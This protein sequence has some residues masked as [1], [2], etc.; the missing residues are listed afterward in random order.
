MRAALNGTTGS[1]QNGTLNG[2]TATTSGIQ[3]RLRRD[4][5]ANWESANPVLD[6]GEL[7]LTTDTGDLKAGDGSTAHS[8]LGLVLGSAYG[9]AGMA[10][11]GNRVVFL[12][13]SITIR[14]DTGTTNQNWG[15]GWTTYASLL[16]GGKISKVRN[17]GVAGNT[18]AQMLARFDTDVTP[19]APNV[20]SILAGTNDTGSGV[21]LATTAT[22]IRSMVAKCFAIGALPV[23]GTIP[24]CATGT[25]ANRQRDIVRL[26]EWITRYAQTSGLPLIDFYSTLVD[27]TTGGY[28][29]AYNSGDGIH[30]SAAGD[31]VMGQ[32]ASDV[33]SPLIRAWTPPLVGFNTE[34]ESGPINGMFLVDTNSDGVPNNW[35]GAGGS[36]GFTHSIVTDANVRGQMA[37]IQQTANAS[38]RYLYSG[39]IPGTYTASDVL[40]FGAVVTSDGG[41]VANMKIEFFT[42]GSVSISSVTH[43]FSR[44]VTRGVFWTEVTCPANTAIVA[45]SL[46]ANPG[47]GNVQWGRVTVRN[48]TGTGILAA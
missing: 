1:A 17:A 29:S 32:L 7:A 8:S 36:S 35:T 3:I 43:Q 16:S 9:R 12:G 14:N 30:P 34:P 46:I 41:V 40:G 15:D 38:L 24:P 6:A 23:L 31:L 18:S 44:A 21:A 48:L 39:G 33:L 13:D 28:Q 4:T 26:N 10:S 37:K 2:G 11:L 25:P 19:Y 47:T 22:N 27:T 45:I 42:A 5:A 20:V